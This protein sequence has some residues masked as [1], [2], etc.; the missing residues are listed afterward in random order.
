MKTQAENLDEMI[1]ENRN[2]K[3]G[4]YIL[5]KNYKK[6]VITATIIAVI[7]FL[8]G[9]SVPLI[10]GWLNEEINEDNFKV[11]VTTNLKKINDDTKED[12]P[13]LP[14]EKKEKT[15]PE[16]KAPIVTANEDE[17][18][19]DLGDLIENTE[20]KNPETNSNPEIVITDDPKPTIIEEEEL[21]IHTIVEEMPEFVGGEVAR[22]KFLT[23][24]INYPEVAKQSGITGTVYVTFVVEADGKVSSVVALREVPGGCTEEALRV[25]KLMPEWTP[26]RQNGK[27]VR[28]RLNMPINFRL[29]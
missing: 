11:E 12:L 16:F 18:T 21:K 3:Y 4:A 27:P 15:K 8:S 5:R 28:V 20:N 7:L 14:E 17:V 19:D 24:N 13:E 1:F 2:K 10:A 23:E 26:G 22:I 9:I 6:N 29:I 25:T